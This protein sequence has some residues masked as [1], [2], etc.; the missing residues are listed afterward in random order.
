MIVPPHPALSPEGRGNKVSPQQ[1]AR[2]RWIERVMK[3]RD[4]A[5]TLFRPLIRKWFAERL[6]AVVWALGRSPDN[7]IDGQRF[8]SYDPAGLDRR[9]TMTRVWR[10]HEAKN[11]FTEAVMMR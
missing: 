10:F 8:P 6:T 4:K 3:E 11:R 5:L 9:R 7:V 1:A 2:N